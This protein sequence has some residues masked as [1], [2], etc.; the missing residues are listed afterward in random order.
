MEGAGKEGASWA[1]EEHVRGCLMAMF[2]DDEVGGLEV[3]LVCCGCRT[4][5]GGSS[6]TRVWT[7]CAW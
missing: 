1:E 4:G 2:G 5:R 3:R 6:L 7:T